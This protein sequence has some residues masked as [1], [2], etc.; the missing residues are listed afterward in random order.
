MGAQESAFLPNSQVIPM[1]EAPPS[2]LW[3]SEFLLAS[4]LCWP[5]QVVPRYLV[6]GE[7]VPGPHSEETG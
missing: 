5:G 1:E 4:Q 3:S 6:P 2:K 7:T